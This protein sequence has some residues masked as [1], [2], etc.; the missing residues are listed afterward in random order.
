MNQAAGA[1]GAELS[2]VVAVYNDVRALGLIFL[3]L[4]RQT[5][6]RFE[7]IVADDGSG[8]AVAELVASR[9]RASRYGVRHLWQE[10]AG[11]RKNAILNRAVA[12]ARSPYLVFIDGDCIPHRRFLEDH[13]RHAG[14]ET[15]LCGRIDAEAVSSGRF[16]RIGTRLL[17]DGLR[18]RSSW[19]EDAVRVEN[20][21]IRRLLHPG[22]PAILG[23]N[24]SVRREW[25]ERINGFNED[26][27]G[28]GLGEDSDVAFRLGLA[29]ARLGSLRNL[30]VL[31]HLHHPRTRV[32]E[33]N[34]ILYDRIVASREMVCRNGL[35][36]LTETGHAR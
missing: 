26:Y 1:S 15:V 24:F 25:L 22:P 35:V 4:D 34:R 36:K 33:E 7:L 31:F 14:P 29:G 30:A 10:D 5:F 17:V 13:A 21:F 9:G 23:C 28:P 19:I 27:R 6:G 2:L 32:G 3:A 8:P 16:E 18:G 20:P 11:F 12:E